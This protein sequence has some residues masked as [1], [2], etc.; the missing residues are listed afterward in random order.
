MSDTVP[1]LRGY[2]QHLERENA[3]L[4][5]QIEELRAAVAALLA[6]APSETPVIP[7]PTR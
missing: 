6:P 3:D 4:R 2:I 1:E 7:E 5:R